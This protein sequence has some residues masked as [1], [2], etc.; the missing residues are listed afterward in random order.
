MNIQLMNDQSNVLKKSYKTVMEMI[1]D[2]GYSVLEDAPTP[3]TYSPEEE[4]LEVIGFERGSPTLL[5]SFLIGKSKIGTADITPFREMM[6]NHEVKKAIFIF[7][8]LTVSDPAREIIQ[9]LKVQNCFI[10]IFT[11]LETQINIYRT[12]DIKYRIL[13]LQEKMEIMK[14]YG[15]SE[16]QCLFF[17]STDPIPVYFG[18]NS[19]DMMEIIRPDEPPTYRIVK[20]KQT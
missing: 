6:K 18:A 19:G 1:A 4:F 10:E 17:H 2:R 9:D 11:F 5:V 20:Q 8:G 3:D 14:Q 7:A 13:P 15:L 16:K 12:F